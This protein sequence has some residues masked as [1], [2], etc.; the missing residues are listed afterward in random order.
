MMMNV[1]F[2]FLLMISPV[3]LD[4]N[5]YNGDVDGDTQVHVKDVP[6]YGDDD[7]DDDNVMVARMMIMMMVVMV[8]MMVV[9]RF[10]MMFLFIIVCVP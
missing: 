8:I 7:D 6:L 9:Y 1:L 5:D 4:N 3:Y 10:E 2:S